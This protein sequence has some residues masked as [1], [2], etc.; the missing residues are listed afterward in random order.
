M[1]TFF[2]RPIQK[3][4][5]S[6]GALF[7][8]YVALGILCVVFIPSFNTARL[9]W[10]PTAIAFGILVL[11]GVELWPAVLLGAFTISLINGSIAPTA[12]GIAAANTFEATAAAYVLRK[13]FDFNPMFSRLR[14]TLGFIFVSL[15]FTMFSAGIAALSQ[16]LIGIR[17][18]SE[19]NDLWAA[20]WIGHSVTMLWVSPFVIR[21]M[22]RPSFTK[23]PR[24]LLEGIAVFVPITLITFFLFWTPYTQLGYV[25]LIYVLILPLLWAALRTGPRGMTLALFITGLLGIGGML[26]GFGPGAAN[27]SAKS[28]LY[29]QTLLGTLSII[30]LTFTSIVEERKEANN[31][32]SHHVDQLEEALKKIRAEDQAK[33]DFIAILAHELRNPLAPVVSSLELLKR[34]ETAPSERTEPLRVMETHVATMSRLLDDLLDISRISRQKFVLQKVPVELSEVLKRSIETSSDF[35]KKSQHTFV[36]TLPTRPILLEADEFRLEQV[37]V[38]LLNNAAKYTN[39][40]GRI[41]MHAELIGNQA[42]VRVKDNGIGI[43]PERTKEIFERFGLHASEPA[44][45]PGGLRIGLSITKQMV[46]LHGGVVEVR[47]KGEGHGSEFIV[48]LPAFRA[49]PLSAIRYPSPEQKVPP[50]DARK[51]STHRILIVDD[52]E[53][54]AQGLGKLLQ[55][56]GH[57][58]T[59]SY[60]GTDAL[61]MAQRIQ[62]DIILLDIGLPDI[63]GHEVARRLKESKN[64]AP[65]VA[66]TGY[67]QSD[68]KQKAYDAGFVHHLTKPVSIVDVEAAIENFCLQ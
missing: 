62:P 15:F 49:Q 64:T 53:A 50:P 68:D 30:F 44:R 48:R 1:N 18:V 55:H 45:L 47:S 9:V 19:A 34:Q 27:V 52:N 63:D 57:D 31:A 23:T 8:I 41:E 38:N 10:P 32:L 5:G 67:G 6:A 51:I 4:L 61:N 54:A 65:I 7:L 60:T 17:T 24:E 56:S 36:T 3:Y 39:S 40:G 59:L 29:M 66:L 43:P 16:L 26:F 2:T 46:E 14:D 37:F 22:A 20:W 25:S 11:Y 58:V 12:A 33:T 42:V 21:W 28:L 35:I 13:Y